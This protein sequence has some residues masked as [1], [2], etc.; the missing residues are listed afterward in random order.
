[1]SSNTTT[2]TARIGEDRIAWLTAAGSAIGNAGV[3]DH[4]ASAED[5]ATIVFDNHVAAVLR[6]LPDDS[7]GHLSDGQIWFG[8]MSYPVETSSLSPAQGPDR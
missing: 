4:V 1:M 5:P 7:D 2:Y 6:D 3:L 8:G